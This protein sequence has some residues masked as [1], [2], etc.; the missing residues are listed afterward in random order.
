[1]PRKPTLKDSIREPDEATENLF[2]ELFRSYEYPLYTLAC[3]LTKCDDTA[4]DIIQEVFL[5][6]WD[7]RCQLSGV[8]Q[9]EAFLY[10]LTRNKTLDFLRKVSADHRL[11]E[12]IWQSLKEINEDAS[13]AYHVKEYHAV[14]AKAIEELPPQRKRIYLLRTE[15]SMNYQQIADE[16]HISRHTV[17]HQVSSALEFIRKAIRKNFHFFF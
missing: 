8:E 9:I 11:K 14:I 3:R 12:A 2:I 1:M 16:L 17:K 13:S 10:R 15:E 6:L 7:I 4:K 5:K